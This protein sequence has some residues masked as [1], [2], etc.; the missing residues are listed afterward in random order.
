[1]I[2][3]KDDTGVIA[4]TNR[5]HII[6]SDLVVLEAGNEQAKFF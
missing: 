5:P 1:V 3:R 6:F 4:E 2:S